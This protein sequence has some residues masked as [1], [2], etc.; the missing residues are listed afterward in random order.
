MYTVCG[1]APAAPDA[2]EQGR[3]QEDAHEDAEHEEG[4]QERV[5]GTEGRPEEHELTGHHV[6]QDRRLAIDA[7]PREDRKEDDENPTDCPALTPEASL[8]TAS[9]SAIAVSHPD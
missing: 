4:Q 7:D 9:G 2:S 5:R 8:S 6:Q 3:E 1:Q